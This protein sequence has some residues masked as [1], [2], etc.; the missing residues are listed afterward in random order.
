VDTAEPAIDCGKRRI[1]AHID[2]LQVS[3]L[4]K[5]LDFKCAHIGTEPPQLEYQSALGVSF[6]RKGAFEYRAGRRRT[7]IHSGVVLLENPNTE[8]IISHYGEL[9]DECTAIQFSSAVFD[10]LANATSLNRRSDNSRLSRALFSRSTIPV[11]P[12]M[13][14]IHSA[15]LTLRQNKFPARTLKV[16]ALL[17]AVLQEVHTTLGTPLIARSPSLNRKMRDF[18]LD[19][20]DRAKHFMRANFVHD[21]TLLEIARSAG[22]SVFHF[23]HIFRSFTG[24]TPWK[25][26]VDLR[27]AH[28][29]LLLQ[30]TSLS[31]TEICF[32]SGFNSVE[33][34]IASFHRR[35]RVSPGKHRRHSIGRERNSGAQ[36]RVMAMGSHHFPADSH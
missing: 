16:D 31:V 6:T 30:Y 29:R 10:E 15:L 32:E 27:L 36:R 17:I 4:G 7:C 19:N 12:A 1:R 33:H 28:A 20:I 11:T 24:S 8:R 26:L 23:M 34:F 22:I 18:Y 35:Y 14:A 5:V 3:S 9:K 2:V 13:E 25:Y 21:L